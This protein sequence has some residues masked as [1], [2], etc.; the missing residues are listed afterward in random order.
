MLLQQENII[1]MIINFH[2]VT[3]HRS[4]TEV[5]KVTLLKDCQR[6]GNR[7]WFFITRA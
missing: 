4:A 1:I 2:Y 6:V 3:N 5:S 7:P